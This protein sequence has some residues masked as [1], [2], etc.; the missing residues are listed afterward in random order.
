MR[1]RKLYLLG[2]TLLV[3]GAA[4]AAPWPQAHEGYFTRV[5]VSAEALE[6]L[7]S[8]RADAYAE[9]GLSARWSLTGKAETVRFSEAAELDRT[10]YRATLRRGL[11]THKGWQVGAEVGALYG[12]ASAGLRG[13]AGWG[14]EARL[15]GGITGVRGHQDFYAFADLAAMSYTDSCTRL[16]AEFGYGAELPR[17]FFH[18]QQIWLEGG[19]GGARSNK[20]ESQLGYHFKAVDVALGFRQSFASSF[21]EQA[22]L[23]AF[24]RRG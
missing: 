21:T 1:G 20:V 13:C 5:L 6:D 16:R 24:V 3:G 9:Y 2:T 12:S 4:E 22:V 17:D 23:I 8:V 11:V 10:S 18:T 7:Q 19:D 14:A 15:S